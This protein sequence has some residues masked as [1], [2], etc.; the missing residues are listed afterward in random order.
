MIYDRYQLID[1]AFKNLF[2]GLDKFED[3]GYFDL[4]AEPKQTTLDADIE[5][6]EVIENCNTKRQDKS[7]KDLEEAED[8]SVV[9]RPKKEKRVDKDWAKFYRSKRAAKVESKDS[10]LTEGS[11]KVK[12]RIKRASTRGTL[13][14]ASDKVTLQITY[15]PYERYGSSGL[16]TIKVLGKDELSALKRAIDEMLL[17]ITRE[18]IEEENMSVDD[19]I[20][21][22]ECSNGDGCDY[23]VE[24]KNLN[25]GNVLL[26]SD[27][28]VE[29]YDDEEDF[30]ESY[31]V[32]A[33]INR[34]GLK[35]S[36]NTR[37][38]LR[39]K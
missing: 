29:E 31:K 7:K 14:E 18:Q 3:D 34:K 19:I 13:T 2:E 22:I 17:Y 20:E 12:A 32:K 33:K 8:L 39:R 16:K 38:F 6:K 4:E 26:S 35:E 28:E 37:K 23:I 30:D 1:S 10:C 27:Y 11:K 24:I 9:T 25:T 5:D 21:E 36:C 15:E